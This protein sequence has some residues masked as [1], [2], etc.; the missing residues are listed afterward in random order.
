MLSP[1][2][3]GHWLLRVTRLVRLG[4]TGGQPV[5]L[6]ESDSLGQM[7][8]QVGGICFTITLKLQMVALPQGSTAVQ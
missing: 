4:I 6:T 8:D 7:T 2:G 5:T 3:I 1:P